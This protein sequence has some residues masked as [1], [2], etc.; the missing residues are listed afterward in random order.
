MEKE[1]PDVFFKICIF[2]DGGVGKTSLVNKYLTGIFIDET[3][4]TIG[5]DFNTKLIEIESKKVVLQI[6]DFAGENHFRFFLPS[7]V[8]GASGAIFLYDLTREA[9]LR[10]LPDWLDV[11]QEGLDRNIP[12]IMAGNKLD[13]KHKRVI[14]P[15]IALEIAEGNDFYGFIE[16]S[17]KTG[18]NIEITFKTLANVMMENA[19][20]LTHNL[21]K[22]KNKKY[23]LFKNP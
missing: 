14:P 7:Y 1:L 12:L 4:M 13:L 16:C 20:L 10:H 5:V 6:W 11:L 17:A 2:G 23:Y 8:R 15:D 19:N 22:R 9:S 18:Q 3:K 21:N